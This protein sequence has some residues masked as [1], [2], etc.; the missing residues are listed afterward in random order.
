MDLQQIKA[1]LKDTFDAVAD[2]YDSR[3]LR[4]FHISA[5]NLV[6]LLNLRGNESILD[7]ATGT[8]HTAAVLAGALPRGRVVGVDLS[9]RMID[10]ARRKMSALGLGNV[11][12]VEMDMLD[13]GFPANTFDIVVSTF[14][15]FFAPDMDAQLGRMTA[16][17]KPGGKIAVST[18]RE[19]Y[20][21]PMRDMMITRL[22]HYGVPP[23][24]Q[25]W[26]AVAT[27]D[28]CRALFARAGLRTIQV[29]ERACG[30]FLSSPDE[31][32]EV[33][34][35]AGFRRML[36]PLSPPDRERFRREH[37]EEIAALRGP[38]GIRLSVPVL[39]TSAVKL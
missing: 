8:G 19:D 7:V 11:E 15:I 31:W 3:P 21:S 18:F 4:F 10:Q 26:R 17:T 12:L 39:Y 34:W 33:I 6:G 14:G 13:L 5:Q 22:T 36:S 20:F 25:S 35:N 28:G 24:P 30:Y 16:V 27:V 37:L 32:W 38:E 29:E 1:A 2:V 9:P 23:P